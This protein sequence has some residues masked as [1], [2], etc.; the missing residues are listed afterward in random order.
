MQLESWAAALRAPS[1]G[2]GLLGVVFAEQSQSSSG[3]LCSHRQDCA[4][5]C[6]Q[7]TK[8]W[9]QPVGAQNSPRPRRGHR[10]PG[11]QHHMEGSTLGEPWLRST[12]QGCICTPIQVSCAPG[13]FWPCQQ[14]CPTGLVQDG[15]EGCLWAPAAV[16]QKDLLVYLFFTG[17]V[18]VLVREIPRDTESC[19]IPVLS[20]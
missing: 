12:C 14:L 17:S 15:H 20:P 8:G 3:L 18:H 13:A 19:S 11:K 4:A 16:V 2:R 5:Q 1:W 7:V 6:R 9:R 10:A